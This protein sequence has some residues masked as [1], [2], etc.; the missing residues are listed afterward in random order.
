MD[1]YTTNKRRRL[2]IL[3][4]RSGKIVPLFCGSIA[5]ERIAIG[6]SSIYFPLLY[7]FSAWVGPFTLFSSTHAYRPPCYA[8]L[9]K[10]CAFLLLSLSVRHI[11]YTYNPS[12]GGNLEKQLFKSQ[13]SSLVEACSKIYEGARVPRVCNTCAALFLFCDDRTDG[14]DAR[15]GT[16]SAAKVKMQIRW[17]SH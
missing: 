11:G 4:R 14:V 17:N 1:K 5:R 13:V 8:S 3:F 10:N 2:R 7:L 9:N 12:L 15:A 6:F 16:K